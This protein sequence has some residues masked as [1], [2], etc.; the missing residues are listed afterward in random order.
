MFPIFLFPCLN[1]KKKQAG[2]KSKP[3]NDL[4]T[5]IKYML[6]RD[7]QIIRIEVVLNL[8]KQCLISLSIHFILVIFISGV[9]IQLF[10]F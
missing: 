4:T 8:E 6:L 3:N 10:T 9:Y 1:P 2:K 7:I 5:K